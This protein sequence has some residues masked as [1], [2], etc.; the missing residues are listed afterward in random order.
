ML[1]E[2]QAKTA[3]AKALPTARVEDSIKYRNVYLFR[4]HLPS[5]GEEDYDPFFSVDEQTGEVRDFSVITDGDIS[6]IAEL[7]AR[8]RSERR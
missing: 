7:F 3:L 8:N 5:P 1:D 4:V 2:A 6:E